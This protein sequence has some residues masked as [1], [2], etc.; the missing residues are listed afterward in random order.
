MYG[1]LILLIGALSVATVCFGT[2]IPVGRF[3]LVNRNM[4]EALVANALAQLSCPHVLI[5]N[6]T[7]KP[8]MLWGGSR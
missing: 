1:L 2:G 3:S 8:R 6:V 7:L 5:N 4:G